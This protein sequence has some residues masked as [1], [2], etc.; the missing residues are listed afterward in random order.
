MQTCPSPSLCFDVVGGQLDNLAF[1][2]EWRVGGQWIL[3]VVACKLAMCPSINSHSQFRRQV[4]EWPV[5]VHMWFASFCR[6][7]SIHYHLMIRPTIGLC[8]VY[9]RSTHRA[10]THMG[11]TFS[12]QSLYNRD[13]P[14]RPTGP[15]APTGP[16]P[17]H[18]S[19][20]HGPLATPQHIVP[21]KF[22]FVCNSYKF[23]G[24]CIGVVVLLRAV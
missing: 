13:T 23:I 18:C 14:V 11:A 21:T 9:N 8:S 17:A 22:P 7:I 6:S 5:Y 10:S 1:A 2:F 12:Q 16:M 24:Q 4:L 20:P 15:R 19:F 3:L